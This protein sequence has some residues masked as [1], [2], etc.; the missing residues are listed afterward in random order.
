[1][2]EPTTQSKPSGALGGLLEPYARRVEEALRRLLR[3]PETPPRLDE[4]MRYCVFGSGKRLR[5]ALLFVSAEATGDGQADELA[6][7][8]AAAVELVHCYSLAHDD[9]P[10]MDDDRLRR[11]RAT[12]H[13]KFGEAM[14]I[15]VGDALLTRAF[16]L[17]A[18]ADDKRCPALAAELARGAGPAG[19]IAGQA[20][21]MDLCDLPEGEEGLRF[22]PERKTAALFRAAARMGAIC[23]RASA[24]ELSAVGEYAAM[25][26]LAFQLVD[27]V[28]DVTASA[29][30]IGKTP[31][32]DA[33]AGKRTY[34]SEM[35]IDRARELSRQ[36]T[37]RAVEALAPLGERGGKLKSLAELL[38]GRTH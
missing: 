10:A 13:V 17:L 5:P 27:D 36:I 35:G 15:L 24:G 22:V 20:A 6:D 12:A 16:G 26:G 33:R 14:A 23:S 7:T 4:A 2:G 25:L 31:G 32:K 37:C 1:M 28:L 11:G 29:E 9:L 8:A 30:Q 18:E 19:V 38:G 3:E 21:D 34:V